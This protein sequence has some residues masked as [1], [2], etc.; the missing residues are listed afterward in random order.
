MLYSNN[1]SMAQL[2]HAFEDRNLPYASPLTRY[3]PH[4]GAQCLICE[5]FSIGPRGSLQCPTSPRIV[6]LCY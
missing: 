3:G 4:S 5:T 6:A 2:P 1:K